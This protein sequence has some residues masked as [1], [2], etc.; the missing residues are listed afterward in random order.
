MIIPS[1]R[2]A[3]KILYAADCGQKE[4]A[5]ECR[6]EKTIAAGRKL[7]EAKYGS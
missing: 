2:T 6:I 4:Q 7:H 5:V 3:F 1:I